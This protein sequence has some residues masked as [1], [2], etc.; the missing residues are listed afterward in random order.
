MAS[1][2]RAG[3]E[4]FILP[5]GVGH[6]EFDQTL[7]NIWTKQNGL[8]WGG[9]NHTGRSVGIELSGKHDWGTWTAFK[10]FLNNPTEIFMSLY[11]G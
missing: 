11:L 1:G 8:W 6:W 3:G 5:W 10:G 9:G 2:V 4:R 7:A